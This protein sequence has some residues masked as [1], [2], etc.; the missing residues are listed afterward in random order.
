MIIKSFKK[1]ILL[2]IGLTFFGALALFG[3]HFTVVKIAEN[4]V[5]D[6]L[7]TIPKN[8]VGLLLGTAKHLK[9]GR[10]NLY[11]KYRIEAA[12]RLYKAHKIKRILVSGDNSRTDYDEPSDIKNDLISQG[13]P[14]NHIY[15]DYAGFRILDSMVR[16][17][18]I[19]GQNS[20]TVISQ[21]F[22]NERAIALGKFKGIR[23]IAYNSKDV[24][25][26]YGL[27]IQIRE[28]FARLKMF[29]D[30]LTFKSPKFLGET[31]TI[32]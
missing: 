1:I 2:S 3:A 6:D 14:A 13:I 23:T 15:L 24:S 28:Y 8:K 19:F 9:S 20:V 27:K 17:K 22:H 21:K 30:I 26:K 16:C 31:V 12:V 5:F 25:G 32:S 7:Q 4:Q 18:K 11:Y 10:V 29:L